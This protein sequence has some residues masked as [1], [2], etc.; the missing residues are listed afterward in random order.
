MSD[1]FILSAKRTPLG[2]F[3]GSLAPL[4]APRLG[5][6]AIAAALDASG[7][8]PGTVEQTVMGNVLQAGQGQAPARQAS[9][10]AGLPQ[11]TGA[12]TVHKV[13]GSGMRAIMDGAN[14]I[15]VGE[16]ST[17]VAGGME[18]MSN[19]PHLLERSRGGYRLGD[20]SITDSMIKDGLWDPYDNQHMGNCAELCARKYDFSREA[21]D[22]YARESY[23]RAQ[24]AIREGLFED[25]IEAVS[26]PQRKG[27]PVLVEQ[28]EEPFR[29]S[30]KKMATLK[31][32]FEKGGSVTAG[33]ASTLSDGA[34]A[35]ILSGSSDHGPPLARIVAAASFAQE[36]KWFTT[37]PVAAARAALDRSGLQGK[38]IDLWEVN[39]AFA[40]VA[41]AFVREFDL[42]PEIVNQRG[43]AVAL[44]HPIGCSGARIV[45]T[46]LHNLLQEKKRYGCASL[47]IGGG[48]AT[49][50][51]IENLRF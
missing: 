26:V 13:C 21:Q 17:V 3:L 8:D 37:S 38:D 16:W 42:N 14:G 43:G 40:V 51:V 30:L 1:V 34:A 27:A 18:S 6:T 5:A 23:A 41:M 7:V 25:E 2:S 9:L 10:Y 32:A 46:L 39:E 4:P 45:T 44:G 12:I 48:E 22:A 28:D 36:P 47:C 35:L 33:N 31:P 19:A 49:A 20:V 50:M 24:R 29:T 15:R 11:S